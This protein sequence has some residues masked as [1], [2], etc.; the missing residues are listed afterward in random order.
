MCEAISSGLVAVSSNI[1]AIPE[2]VDDGRTG[3]LAPPED[4]V[5][6]ADRIESLYF[7]HEKFQKLSQS[8]AREMVKQ[9]GQ[10]ATIGQ[11]IELVRRKV[12]A[13]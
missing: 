9:C 3:L 6:L 1:A 4:Y 10:V 11:E 13:L 7:D 5:G 12:G 8:G 2:F